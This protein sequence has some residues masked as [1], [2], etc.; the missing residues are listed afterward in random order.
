MQF[1]VKVLNKE[2]RRLF[3]YSSTLLEA[4][5][6]LLVEALGLSTDNIFTFILN[7]A[8]NVFEIPSKNLLESINFMRQS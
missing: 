5:T 2:R 3:M 1:S 6:I 8:N 4:G 7:T